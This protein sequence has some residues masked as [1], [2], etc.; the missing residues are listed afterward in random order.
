MTEILE[1][2]PKSRDTSVPPFF[3]DKRNAYDCVAAGTFRNGV[4]SYCAVPAE[5][6]KRVIRHNEPM[7]EDEAVKVAEFL[8]NLHAHGLI[9]WEP[10]FPVIKPK[11]F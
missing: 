3:V 5:I 7:S 8:N 9:D 11:A 4:T 2:W 6:P 1:V 10:E